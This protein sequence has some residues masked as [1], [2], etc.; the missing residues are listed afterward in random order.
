MISG[1]WRLAAWTPR[2]LLALGGLVV[3]LIVVV[4][5]R[6]VASLFRP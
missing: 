4:I 3:V 5:L 6:N 2:L 1:W